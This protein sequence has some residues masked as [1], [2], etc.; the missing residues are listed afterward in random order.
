MSILFLVP[1]RVLFMDQIELFNH[2]VHLEQFN[3]KQTDD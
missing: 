3:C 2:L 1:V